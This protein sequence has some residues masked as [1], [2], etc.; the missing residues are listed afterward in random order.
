MGDPV[1]QSQPDGSRV[2]VVVLSYNSRKWLERCIQSVLDTTWPRTTVVFVDNGSADGSFDFVRERFPDICHIQTGANLGFAGGN[3]VGIVH[4]LQTGHDYVMLLNADA[5]MEPEC[6]AEMVAVMESEPTLG[7]L[8]ALIVGYEDDRLDKNWMQF[9]RLNYQCLQ[10]LWT[11]TVDRWYE[12][13]SGSGAAMLM[14]S[15]MLRAIGFID[16]VFFMYFEE[17]DLIRRGRFHGYRSAFSTRAVVHHYNHLESSGPGHS[18]GI[19]FERG[20]MIYTLK[21]QEESLLKCVPKFLA[22]SITRVAGAVLKRQWTRTG[23][24]LRAAG[25]LYLKAPGILWR[26]NLEM[27]HPE[28][29]PELGTLSSSGSHS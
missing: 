22:E 11:G 6:L 10:D 17:I 25:E 19:R 1:A 8:S 20:H 18:S 15:S 16:P 21:N 12:T 29:L 13:D 4:A 9:M 7:F 26:R 5:W 27:R 28:L 23:K 2:A 3:N 24:L 14:R